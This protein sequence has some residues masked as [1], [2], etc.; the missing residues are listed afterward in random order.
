[1]DTYKT[2]ALTVLA[3]VREYLPPDGISKDEFISRVIEAVDNPEFN[4]ALSGGE[5]SMKYRITKH[6][7]D[8]YHVETKGLLFWDTLH[9][10]PGFPT[11]E[12]AREFLRR[13]RNP[14]VVHEE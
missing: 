8:D 9:S 3:A 4:E 14:E 12:K 6:G 2:A 13:Y 5:K 7:D 10:T 1:M 11:L